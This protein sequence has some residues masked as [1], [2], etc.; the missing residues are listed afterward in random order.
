V[1]FADLAGFTALSEKLYPEE[2]RLVQQ[3][4]FSAISASI[5]VQS[6]WIEK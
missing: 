6:G 2:V 5:R 1:L 3:A 4:Y